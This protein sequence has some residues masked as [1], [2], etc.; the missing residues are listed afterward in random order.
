MFLVENFL[1]FLLIDVDR[2]KTDISKPNYVT[3][4]D[5]IV[6]LYVIQVYIPI[7]CFRLFCAEGLIGRDSYTENVIST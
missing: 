7:V 4:P 2:W 5:S 3:I 1:N 6:I